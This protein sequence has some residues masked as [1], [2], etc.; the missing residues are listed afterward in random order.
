MPPQLKF[1]SWNI[2]EAS[3][4]GLRHLSSAPSFLNYL[5]SGNSSELFNFGSIAVSP[6]GEAIK[7]WTVRVQDSG[8]ISN[9]RFW[10]NQTGLLNILNVPF[11][12]GYVNSGSW[13][14]NYNPN[15]SQ[16]KILSGILPLSQNI[17]RQD[18]GIVIGS[19]IGG[20]NSVYNDLDVSQFIYTKLFIAP[21]AKV[22]LY[23][24]G[25]S[26]VLQFRLTYDFVQE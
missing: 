8:I 17:F 1:T 26:G 14:R 23:N 12:L 10:A 9:L 2:G 20:P 21:N 18:G 3:P 13:I 4:V 11:I 6:S 16:I 7:A 24:T 19:G 22:G 25:A 5:S 15:Q